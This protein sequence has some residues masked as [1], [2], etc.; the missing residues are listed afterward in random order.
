MNE[1]EML[2]TVY[3][4]RA[5]GGA[6]ALNFFSVLSAYL[7]VAYLVG[8]KLSSFQLWGISDLY[9]LYLYFPAVAVQFAVVDLMK[10]NAAPP[11]ASFIAIVF[12]S[13]WVVSIVFMLQKRRESRHAM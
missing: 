2:Q 10:L 7:A 11:G 5:T 6:D 8:D 9:S 12:A 4:I 13:M 3:A 1:Y